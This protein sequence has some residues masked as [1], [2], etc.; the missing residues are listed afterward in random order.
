MVDHA[1]SFGAAAAQ[2]D[3]FRPPYPATAASWIAG[4]PPPARVVDL[5]AGT[6]ILTRLL[7]RLDYTVVPVEPDE[8]M[9]AQLAVATPGTTAL[10][11]AAETIPLADATADALVVGQAYHWFDRDRAHEEVAR[12]LRPGGTFGTI[13]NT[14]D[15]SVP[16]VAALSA[17]FDSDERGDRNRTP[18]LESFGERFEPL[19]RAEFRHD[20]PHT[21][22]TLV[23][24]VTTRS[25][26]LIATP[27]RQREIEAAVWDLATGHP[28]LAGRDEF[29][30][31][32]TT[33]CFRARRR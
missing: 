25:Y 10:A 4:G 32:Y 12:V 1:L 31:P 11:G 20:T 27:Q 33:T 23:G 28:D 9:R 14:R 29:E 24:M 21:A 3:Q 2:Y 19:E 17:L 30:L 13:W 15:E 26:Y 7:L 22:A 5:G 8:G 6:G 18:E 16:W